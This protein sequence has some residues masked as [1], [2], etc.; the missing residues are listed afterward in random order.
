MA[1]NHASSSAGIG[2][3]PVMARSSFVEPDQP[4]HAPEGDVVEE[5]VGLLLLLGGGAPVDGVDDGLGRLDRLV[6]LAGLVRVGGEG[7][8]HAGVDLLPRGARR[9]SRSGA[10]H[11]RRRRSGRGQ[12]TTS[13]RS[14]ATPL[15]PVAGHARSAMWAMGR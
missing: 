11:G 12:G 3:V 14:P 7:P 6:E 2:A 15:V 8:D 9:T 10:R 4:A 1:R 13:P 5:G